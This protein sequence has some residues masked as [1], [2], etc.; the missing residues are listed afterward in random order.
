MSPGGIDRLY[1]RAAALSAVRSFFEKRGVIE[2]DTPLLVSL[3]PIDPAIDL[4]EVSTRAE[5]RYLSSSPEH[6]MKRLLA[7]GASDIY[8]LSH[9]YRDDEIGPL[10]NPVF[11]MVEWYRLG[12]DLDD[13]RQETLSLVELFLGKQKIHHLSY[14]QLFLETTGKDPLTATAEELLSLLSSPLGTP[15]GRLELIDLIY[16]TQ[17]E[18]NLPEGIV[19]L[20]QFLPEQASLSKIKNGVPERFELYYNRIELANGYQELNDPEEIQKRWILA[21]QIRK[22]PLPMD[23]RFLDELP[24][25]APCSGV[26]LGF[27]RLL[28]CSFGK[29]S[30]KEILPFDW[31]NS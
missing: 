25:M 19:L 13:L 31:Q 24:A 21:N 22:K 20:D 23:T 8:Q 1:H 17:V 28:M 2:V 9:V 4:M 30:L 14:R 5:K 16:A 15:L 26:A 11:T 27:D 7:E 18:P 3:P 12:W 6:L 10:H 29:K